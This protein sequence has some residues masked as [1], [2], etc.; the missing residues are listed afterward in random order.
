MLKQSFEFFKSHQYILILRTGEVLPLPITSLLPVILFPLLGVISTNDI[1]PIYMKVRLNKI[2]NDQV[3]MTLCSCQGTQ[4]FYMGSL[5]IALAVEES[6]NNQ[7]TFN[8]LL[9]KEL[10]E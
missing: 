10:K 7:C 5:M 3:M 4:M 8:F 1:A 6:G 9:G 2:I